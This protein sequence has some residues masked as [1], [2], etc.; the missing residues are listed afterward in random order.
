VILEGFK[1]QKW[2]EKK[3]KKSP[4]FYIQF[5]VPNQKYRNMIKDL[6]FIFGL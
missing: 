1:P 4:D 6:Y 3:K 2:E 5:S